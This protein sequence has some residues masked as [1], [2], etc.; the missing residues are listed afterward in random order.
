M[1]KR[2]L[3]KLSAREAETIAKP[4]RHGDGG[5]LYL[6]IEAG[7]HGRR[8]WVFLYRVRGSSKRRELGLGPAKGKGKDGLSLAD[9]VKDA[10]NDEIV[11]TP[12]QIA[13]HLQHIF[14]SGA[15]D[16]FVVAPTYFPGMIEQFCRMVVPEL[17]RR[18][19]FRKEYAGTT[20][21]ENLLGKDEP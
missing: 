20:L 1:A 4:G 16:G 5:G 12:A 14:E 3:H 2:Q 10:K 8:Q 21:R 11:G 9:A 17:Q 15:C 6:A 13:D 19:I 18:G 7:A